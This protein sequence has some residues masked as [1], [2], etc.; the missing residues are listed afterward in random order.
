MEFVY[1]V[2]LAMALKNRHSLVGQI[3]VFGYAYS[4]GAK[5]ETRLIFLVRFTPK[6]EKVWHL[7]MEGGC[8]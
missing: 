2:S 6:G 7:Y 1:S 3:H 5:F 4:L 8:L